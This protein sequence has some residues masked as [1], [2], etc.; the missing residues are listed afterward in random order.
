MA[1]ERFVTNSKPMDH[2]RL[3]HSLPW[4]Q[5]PVVGSFIAGAVL[6]VLSAVLWRML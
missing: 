5:R 1:H 4:W 2:N 3:H 6:G